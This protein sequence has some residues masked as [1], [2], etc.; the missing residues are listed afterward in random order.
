MPKYWITNKQIDAWKLVFLEKKN[1]KKSKHEPLD[2]LYGEHTGLKARIQPFSKNLKYFHDKYYFFKVL[3][4]KNLSC[5]PKT[6]LSFDEFMKKRNNDN[7]IWF[8][9]LSTFDC[10]SG[11]VPFRDNI[12]EI[13]DVK[14][15]QL[16]KKNTC[17]CSNCSRDQYIIQK[18]VNNLLLYDGRKF[19]IR[20]HILITCDSDVYVYKNACMRIS[21]KKHS[22]NCNC[23][24]HQLTNGSLG[25][26]VKY[27][28]RW[29][30][31]ETYYPNVKD[32]IMEILQ[33]MKKYIEKGKYLLIGGDFIFDRTGKAW[34]L[35]F[36]TY[37]NLYYEQDPQMQPTITHMLKSML[38]LL[39]YNK[40]D[41]SNSY[42]SWDYIGSLN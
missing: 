17:R 32:S 20:I 4:N 23:K 19:D 5:I 28:N 40:C 29:S 30:K 13:N 36:N 33:S 11:V 9:K 31:W 41:S 22:K 16:D 39:V 37:P 18:G 8:F 38:D 27:T 1:W 24:K 15:N 6:Y 2:F 42:Y 14:Y 10:G 7:S 3:V 26:D 21:F 34:A 35:E 12:D 25:A